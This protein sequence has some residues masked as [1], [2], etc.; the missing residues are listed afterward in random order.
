LSAGCGFNSAAF[1]VSWPVHYLLYVIAAFC[2]LIGVGWSFHTGELGYLA[3]SL[4]AGVLFGA[5]GKLIHALDMIEEHL[6]VAS[7]AFE[8][9]ERRRQT[10]ARYPQRSEPTSDQAA[11][12]MVD[13]RMVTA[14]GSLPVQPAFSPTTAP[15]LNDVEPKNS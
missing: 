15:L 3:N 10:D 12:P 5:F 11:A 13:R 9:R 8:Q 7:I 2:V 1:L 14:R 4:L 6:R